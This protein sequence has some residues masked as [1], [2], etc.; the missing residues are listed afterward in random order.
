MALANRRKSTYRRVNGHALAK[1]GA[2]CNVP[3][4]APRKYIE[5]VLERIGESER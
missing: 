1:G 3:D 4:A 2:R 5:A